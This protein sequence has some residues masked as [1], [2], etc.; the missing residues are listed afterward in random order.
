MVADVLMRKSNAPDWD[1]L[2]ISQVL[3][4]AADCY[5]FMALWYLVTHDPQSFKPV[6]YRELIL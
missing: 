4:A 6:T 3:P 1:L 5:D 2:A